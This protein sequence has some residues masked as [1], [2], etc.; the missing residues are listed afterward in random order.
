MAPQTAAPLLT[1]EDYEALPEEEGKHYEI[2]EGELF[3]KASPDPR[4]Q[5]I[6][7]NVLVAFEL[8]F[9]EHGGGEVFIGPIGVVINQINV[10]EPDLIVLVKNGAWTIG[11]KR[12][13][14]APDLVVEVVSKGNRR[15]DE[16]RKKAVYE[17]NHVREY[18]IVDPESETV[19]AHRRA[20]EMFVLAAEVGM[21]KGGTLTTPLLPVFAI[22]VATVF[23]IPR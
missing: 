19:R 17:K 3:V 20:G 6:V 21:E 13:H 7:T 5:R 11:D 14:G 23:A 16:V 15:H 18:W 2:V 10:V 22:D 8:Y 9:R 12:I 1:W 4:H